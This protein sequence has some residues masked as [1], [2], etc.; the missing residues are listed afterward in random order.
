MLGFLPKQ[1][2]EDAMAAEESGVSVSVRVLGEI[3]IAIDG[4]AV[5]LP[6]SLRAVALRWVS[7]SLAGRTSR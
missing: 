1:V 7:A 2:L 6:E 3:G 5:A 4:V